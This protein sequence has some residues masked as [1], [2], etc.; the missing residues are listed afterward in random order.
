[1]DVCRHSMW[2]MEKMEKNS[3][4]YSVKNASFNTLHAKYYKLF[5]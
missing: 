4:Y 3:T 2:N 1:M 5:W